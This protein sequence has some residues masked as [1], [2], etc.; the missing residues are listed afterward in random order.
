MDENKF[1]IK[2][3]DVERE[4]ELLRQYVD[5]KNYAIILLIMVMKLVYLASQIIKMKMVV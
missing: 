1:R 5:D 2:I 3:D 4:A